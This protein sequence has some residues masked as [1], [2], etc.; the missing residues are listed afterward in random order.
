MIYSRYGRLPGTKDGHSALGHL[1]DAYYP[2]PVRRA[3][4]ILRS[5]TLARGHF[6]A[7]PHDK[8]SDAPKRAPRNKNKGRFVRGNSA[9][10]RPANGRE[11]HAP[12]RTKISL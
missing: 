5:R 12:L 10:Q 8:A 1:D 6:D 3:K 4:A 2:G 11:R 9:W 7:H